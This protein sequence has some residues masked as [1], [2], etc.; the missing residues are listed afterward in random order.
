MKK[1]IESLMK[2]K[3]EHCDGRHSE[4]DDRLV[5]L[6]TVVEEDTDDAVSDALSCSKYN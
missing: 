3:S 6:V 1:E 4:R 2:D 5:I